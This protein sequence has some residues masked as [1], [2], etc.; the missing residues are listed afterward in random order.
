MDKQRLIIKIIMVLLGQKQ[1]M[2][3]TFLSSFLGF[4]SAMLLAHYTRKANRYEA[5]KH[6]LEQMR[7]DLRKIEIKVSQS[8]SSKTP[9][10]DISPYLAPGWEAAFQTGTINSIIDS[11]IYKG[12]LETYG[13]I[14]R[15]NQIETLFY[16]YATMP[17]NGNNPG[18][19]KRHYVYLNEARERLKNIVQN[20]KDNIEEYQKKEEKKRKNEGLIKWIILIIVIIILMIPV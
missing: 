18:P 9:T 5:N 15:V 2:L 1:Q 16:Q 10:F 13:L 14:V 4:G 17:S 3:F 19:S 8:V 7:E 6:M 11:D 12:I 20:N